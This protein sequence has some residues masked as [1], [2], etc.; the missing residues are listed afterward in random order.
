MQHVRSISLS[1]PWQTRPCRCSF[2]MPLPLA[3]SQTATKRELSN[4]RGCATFI[5]QSS[6]GRWV[7]P[8]GKTHRL[9]P[10]SR[11]QDRG[12]DLETAIIS[13]VT[14]RKLNSI[15]SQ[16]VKGFGGARQLK[17][18]RGG[19]V[20]ALGSVSGIPGRDPGEGWSCTTPLHRDP[21]STSTASQS[22]LESPG[23]EEAGVCS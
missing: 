3:V 11:S 20:G 22:V 18:L 2:G 4:A 21:D 5:Q 6:R 9:S 19:E 8:V 13:V 12:E 7:K 10:I 14:V 16:R 23:S 17:F 1:G 15:P